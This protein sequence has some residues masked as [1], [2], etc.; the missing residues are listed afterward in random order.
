MN[1]SGIR[2]VQSVDEMRIHIRDKGL[3]LPTL[4]VVVSAL[5]SFWRSDSPGN[6][7]TI[8]LVC[9]LP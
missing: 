5:P 4:H 7:K 3:P 8:P 9:A 1:M 6:T 2:P